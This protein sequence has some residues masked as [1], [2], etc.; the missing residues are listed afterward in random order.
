[1][2]TTTATNARPRRSRRASM[3]CMPSADDPDGTKALAAGKTKEELYEQYKVEKAAR[4]KAHEDAEEQFRQRTTVQLQ[5]TSGLA[6]QE[7]AFSTKVE[8]GTFDRPK[9]SRRQR[10]ASMGITLQ[11]LDPIED[12]KLE[13]EEVTKVSMPISPITS[14]PTL[15]TGG[16]FTG[17]PIPGAWDGS[18]GADPNVMFSAEALAGW[19]TVTF[20]DGPL[21]MQLEPTVGDKACKVTGFLDTLGCPSQARASGQIQFDDVVVKVNGKLPKSYEETLEMI[22]V[23]GQRLITFRPGFSYELVD[24]TASM[25]SPGKGNKKKRIGR[26]ASMSAVPSSLPKS[27]TD[28]CDVESAEKDDYGYGDMGYGD[29]GYGD[30]NDMGYGDMGYGDGAPSKKA[31][32]PKAKKHTVADKK[33]SKRGRRASCVAVMP[34]MPGLV[35]ATDLPKE[36][37]KE[38]EPVAPK[39]K[40][41]SRRGRRASMSS[42]PAGAMPALVSA[43]SATAAKEDKPHKEEK[44]SSKHK[45]TC[46]DT[47]GYDPPSED[48]GYGDD[49]EPTPKVEKKKSKKGRRASI[50]AM[51]SALQGDSDGGSKSKMAVIKAMEEAEAAKKE[52]KKKKKDEEAPDS[53]KAEKKKKKKDV[54]EEA[55]NS[56][57]KKK[58]SSS[59]ESKSKSK[60]DDK[61]KK[62]KKE[63]K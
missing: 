6:E 60:S 34:S 7:D 32:S 55:D 29:M 37:L 38:E 14:T 27:P 63:K 12:V 1:M 43:T 8:L 16:L 26:R 18:A 48:M 54:E 40:A 35:S 46:F 9:V 30:S 47:L 10:R 62:K 57:V 53:P 13:L 39:K 19:K 5:E 15:S 51:P 2:E 33:K 31:D 44:K 25:D 61:E 45:V 58:S 56:K 28:V 24:L 36:A 52:K 20:E 41:S 3:S 21:G 22:A 49:A 17:G 11:I 50:A 4:L 59:S 23:G 42:M